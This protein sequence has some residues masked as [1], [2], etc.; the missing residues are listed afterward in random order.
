MSRRILLS[1]ALLVASLTPPAAAQERPFPYVLGSRDAGLLPAGLGL[2]LLGYHFTQRLDSLTA[3]DIAPL[4]P[5]DINAFDRPAARYWSPSWGDASD[6][7]L[8]ALLGGAVVASFVPPVR[9]GRWRNTVTLG[10]MF[11]ES[12]LLVAGV[13]YTTKALAGRNR[14]FV[15]NTNFSVD[16]R[17]ALSDAD[18]QVARQS[19]FS[20]HSAM[21]FATATLMSQLFTDVYG[22][23]TTSDVLWVS[24][25]SVAS[26]TAYARVKA[27]MHY[28]SDVLVGAAVGTAIGLVVPRLHRAGAPPPF[29][30]RAGPGGVTVRIPH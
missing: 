26:V 4:R 18:P 17:L 20:G 1:I 16:E 27:G 28:P 12:Y 3:A 22:R 21:A 8:S 25:L 9:E 24:S 7:T 6:W 5:D 23:S 2:S 15:Y 30:V 29:E 11:A 14:P 10:T 19:F 13:T